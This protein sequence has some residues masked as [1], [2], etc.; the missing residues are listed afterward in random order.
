MAVNY[1]AFCGCELTSDHMII[2]GLCVSCSELV[3]SYEAQYGRMC[4][5]CD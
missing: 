5:G 1:C 4:D 3:G 2:D